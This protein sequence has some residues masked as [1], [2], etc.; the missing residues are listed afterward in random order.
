MD[1]EP[2]RNLEWQIVNRVRETPDTYTYT[3]SPVG[4]SRF[5]F[6]VGQFVTISSFLRRPSESGALEES[7]V[8]R[9]YS[10]ASSP[11]RPLIDLTIKDEKPYGFI[12]PGTHKADGFSA[13]FFEQTK[14]GD[15]VNVRLNQNKTHFL[16]KVAAGIEKNIGLVQMAQ[17]RRDACYNLWRTPKIPILA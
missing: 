15:K 7:F 10:I 6:E 11:T 9:A 12:N 4:G 1:Q 17:N 14:I 3:F 13:Y 16:S 2:N 5:E 8:E